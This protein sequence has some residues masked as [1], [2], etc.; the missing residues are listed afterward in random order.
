MPDPGAGPTQKFYLPTLDGWRAI[1]IL[2][3]LFHH[4]ALLTLGPVSDRWL[5]QSGYEG[6]DVFFAISGLLICWRLL[7][8]EAVRG[9]ISLRAFYIRRAFRI[10]PP[11]LVYLLVIA[12]LAAIGLIA[13]SP[14]ELLAS[15]FF[16]RNYLVQLGHFAVTPWFTG[17]FWSLS[18]EE[19]FYLL[20]PGLLVLTPR[21][22]RAPLL[23]ILTAAVILHR[24]SA[25][26]NPNFDQM[27]YQTDLRLH[28]LL[29]PAMLAVLVQIPSIRTCFRRALVVWP[30]LCALALWIILADPRPILRP[31]P[32]ILFA[33]MV[34]GS[35]LNPTNLFGRLLESPP[36]R[37][38][39][40]ISYSLYLWQQLF[41]TGHFLNQYPLGAF[42]RFPLQILATFMCAILSYRYIERPMIALGHRLA[43]PPIRR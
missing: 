7:E 21:K 9:R 19:H 32:H 35:I 27:R 34:L 42:N 36:L 23:F 33:L 40:R 24:Q 20:L 17:H 28:E 11:A 1:A 5:F 2:A 26:H 43:H 37:W 38:I 29:L 22:L 41:F 4:A 14:K 39:G 30:L 13:A 25:L 16:F 31:A 6:V 8:E 18:V 10:L 12:L 15:L 3:V